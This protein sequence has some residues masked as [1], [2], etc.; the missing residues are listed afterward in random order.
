[1]IEIGYIHY[2][3]M[4]L[5]LL[6]IVLMVLKKDIV[7]VCILGLFIIG[8]LYN[9]NVLDGIE[10]IYKGII[11]SGNEFWSIIVTISLIVAMSNALRDIG[12]DVVMIKPF[13][14]FI[15]T[16][17]IAF[18]VIGLLMTGFSFILWPSPAVV[19]IGAIILPVAVK[20]GLPKIWAAVAMNL[21]GHGVALSADYF[22]Q[23]APSIT[24]KAINIEDPTVIMKEG[25]PLWL[26]MSIVT[27]VTAYIMMLKDIKREIASDTEITK[28]KNIPKVNEVFVVKDIPRESIWVKFVAVLTPVVF[29]V[30]I[31]IMYR[32]ELKGGDAAAL[33]TGSAVFITIIC[34]SIKGDFEHLLNQLSMY[35]KNGFIFGIETFAPILVVGA[36]F[37]IGNQETAIQI[38]GEGASGYLGDVG[39]YLSTKISLS[40]PMAIVI[41]AVTAGISGLGGAGFSALPLVGTIAKTLSSVGNIDVTRLASLGQIFAMWVGGGTVIPWG[42]IAVAAICKVNPMD[43]VRKNL[44][45]VGVG[46]VATILVAMI[47]I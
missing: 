40:I 8:T 10:T 30:N 11:V 23:G 20:S 27:V 42:V 28:D 19:L 47:I 3:Y 36:F 31:F 2:I 7:L 37:F 44:F 38:L 24:A 18:W 4:L 33:L 9:K 14:R 41:Q 6:I 26:T 43:L 21:F 13:N 35:V 15:K 39:L 34:V 22:I 12:V 46:F 17:S 5:I 45:P 1:M 29:L 16:P 25:F 32:Y